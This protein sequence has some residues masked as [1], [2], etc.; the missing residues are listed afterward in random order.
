[1]PREK[2]T[3]SEFAEEEMFNN[4][5]SEPKQKLLD[6]VIKQIRKDIKGVDETAIEE[7]ISTLPHDRLVG[8]L[9][10]EQW[11]EHPKG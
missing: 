5:P 11:I 8:F 9:P 2:G 1:M 3:G 4:K 6:A 7:L 10:E